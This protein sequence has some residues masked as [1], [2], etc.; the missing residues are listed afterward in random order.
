MKKSN[1][2]SSSISVI[3]GI[4]LLCAFYAL[5]Q[6]LMPILIGIIIISAIGYITY[7]IMTNSKNKEVSEQN[8]SQSSQPTSPKT[9]VLTTVQ[10]QNPILPN[11]QIQKESNDY[12]LKIEY[13]QLST[14]GADDVC[15]MCA[16]FEGKIFL[17]TE[18]PQLPLCP[19]CACTYMYYFENDLPPNTAISNKNDF[20]LPAECT[21]MFYKK[22]Q[23]I[24]KER[25]ITK[26]IRLCESQIKKLYEFMEPYISAQFSAPA[27]LACRDLL[28][29]LYMQLGK[30][31]KA[32]NTIKT[33]IKA[34]AYYPEDG[35]TQLIEFEI[36]KKVA[37]E[38]LS[39][40]SQNSGCL[41]RNVYKAMGYE[42]EEREQL[43]N[44]L[45]DSQQIEKEKYNNTNKLFVKEINI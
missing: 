31:E 15:P 40:I 30:W 33:C 20:I 16:Q 41:Q 43:K 1:K 17:S 11:I 24:C 18:A 21:S 23:Q 5:L 34:K 10:N 19:S 32:E 37:T 3:L 35:S 8:I 9:K 13:I 14:S 39:Y 25:D 28:P 29:D 2:E 42:G 4:L 36:Y 38:T 26:R 27:E 7:K 45:R 44:F 22:Q 6:N 12:D